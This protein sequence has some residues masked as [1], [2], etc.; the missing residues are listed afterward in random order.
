MDWGLLGVA[1]DVLSETGPT[2]T[3]G[4]DYYYGHHDSHVKMAPYKPK[5]KQRVERPDCPESQRE[6]GKAQTKIR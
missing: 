4:A 3:K 5:G 2:P 6:N 1:D